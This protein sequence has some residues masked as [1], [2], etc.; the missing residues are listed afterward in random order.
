MKRSLFLFLLSSCTLFSSDIAPGE[1]GMTPLLWAAH[2]GNFDDVDLLLQRG[3]D[4]NLAN[5]F[6][7]TPLMWAVLTRN[8]RIAKLLLDNHAKLDI[9][10]K[11]RRTALDIAKDNQDQAMIQLLASYDTA[12]LPG[13]D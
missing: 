11:Q 6:G 12:S 5:V 7:I 8:T 13:G 9:L 2:D 4:I 1:Y 3:A 10:D